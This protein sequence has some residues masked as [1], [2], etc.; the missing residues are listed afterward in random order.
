MEKQTTKTRIL[1]YL[2]NG[3]EL[4]QLKALK[5]FG[6]TRL[7]AYIHELRVEGVKIDTTLRRN[8]NKMGQHA[9]YT[10]KSKKGS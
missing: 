10:M 4:D 5:M 3:K 7:G 8:K 6:T 2:Q 9:V 1:G